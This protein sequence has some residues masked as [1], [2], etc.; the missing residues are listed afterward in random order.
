V[1]VQD[2]EDV[3]VARDVVPDELEIVMKSVAT[4]LE[5]VYVTPEATLTTLYSPV[6]PLVVITSREPEQV[7]V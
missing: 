4:E 2:T 6:Q 3:P 1:E 7:G 5:K